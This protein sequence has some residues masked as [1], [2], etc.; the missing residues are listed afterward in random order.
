MGFLAARQPHSSQVPIT[1][2]A[3]RPQTIDIINSLVVITT[4]LV[5]IRTAISP[6]TINIWVERGFFVA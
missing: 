2:F 3:Q 5:D 6:V 1:E 4:P